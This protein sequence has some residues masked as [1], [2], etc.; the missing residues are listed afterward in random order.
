MTTPKARAADADFGKSNGH[1]LQNVHDDVKEGL[2]ALQYGLDSRSLPRT[3]G[4]VGA[5]GVGACPGAT[6]FKKRRR[7]RPNLKEKG[8]P[9]LTTGAII[10]FGIVAGNWAKNWAKLLRMKPRSRAPWTKAR[11]L[12][13]HR[14]GLAGTS[15]SRGRG[16]YE[17]ANY[18]SSTDFG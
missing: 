10:T 3:T 1:G 11:P 4:R 6:R 9:G 14:Q 5:G 15:V 12:F 7:G 8:E 13:S 17:D 16:V 18:A 2:A